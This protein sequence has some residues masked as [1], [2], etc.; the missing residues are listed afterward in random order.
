MKRVPYKAADGSW[1][2]AQAHDGFRHLYT[3]E[4]GESWQVL[5]SGRILIRHPDRQ[6]KIVHP[7]GRVE[8]IAP[9]G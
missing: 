2:E 4:R 6:P 3:L 1:R 8:E 9:L 7:S 5:S